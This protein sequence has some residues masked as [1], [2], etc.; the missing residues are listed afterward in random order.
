ML[1]WID[2]Q[3]RTATLGR[4]LAS[5]CLGALLAA[6]AAAADQECS[7]YSTA[8]DFELGQMDGVTVNDDGDLELAL[9]GTTFP[10]M[11]IA[12]AGE[13]TV[14]K[15]DTANNVEI[16]RYKTTYGTATHGAWT[17]TAP[18]RTAVDGDGNVYVANRQFDGKRMSVMKI[19]TE[20]GIDRNGNGGIDTSADTS[21]DGQIQTAEMIILADGN[22]TG[23]LESSEL[24]D[25]RVAW[26]SYLGPADSIGRALCIDDQGF[27]WV[28]DFQNSAYYKLDPANGAVLAGPISVSPLYPYGCLVD[29]NGILYSA[30][31]GTSPTGQ[32][33]GKLDTA[34]GTYLGTYYHTGQG[35]H[36]SIGAGS[37]RVYLAIED[38]NRYLVFDTSTNLFSA[39]GSTSSRGISVDGAG[40][41]VLGRSN[42]RKHRPDGSQV[43]SVT[44]PQGY[45]DQRGVIV[46]GNNDVWVVNLTSN[47]I[48]KFNG[49]T[50]AH[51]T[52]LPVG[53][54]PY[55]YSDATGFA[56]RNISDPSGIWTGII[57][58]GT[59]GTDWETLSWNEDGGNVPAGSSIS[60]EVRANDDQG[61]L[62]F[63][64][65]QP[66]ANG[67]GGLGVIGRFLQ[68]KVTLR[69]NEDDETPVLADFTAQPAVVQCDVNQDCQVDIT[70]VRAIMQARNQTVTESP[71]AM[72]RDG[73]KVITMLDVR[74]CILKCDNPRC[75][76]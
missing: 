30:E 43:W 50:G 36:Y 53:L 41:I 61:Q 76:P 8:A 24:L 10:V 54:S 73:D 46:D 11:W 71:N 12:N 47:N 69:P 6:P 19:L 70:D 52:T 48:S 45:Q 21:G 72:D 64:D 55:T 5:V 13:D 37:G 63:E 60:M 7:T 58:S 2:N 20:G 1:R 44:N 42:I 27:V 49:A 39:V 65:Y 56:F 51:I 34:T 3:G 66:A 38:Q 68:I 31:R 40:D 33:I 62:P 35:T 18:S 26:I 28:G 57:D 59:A 25:E 4:R 29:G 14:S 67:G 32:K 74:Q 22:G 17:G 9:I 75:A 23:E 15:I 16:A